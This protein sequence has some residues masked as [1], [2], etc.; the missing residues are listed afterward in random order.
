MIYKTNWSAEILR[1]VTAVVIGLSL[2]GLAGCV[3][4]P[5]T[6]PE[7]ADAIRSRVASRQIEDVASILTS[8][9]TG[10]VL[11]SSGT[12][13]AVFKPEFKQP[14]VTKGGMAGPLKW[15]TSAFGGQ[16]NASGATTGQALIRQSDGSWAGGTAGGTSS[17]TYTVTDALILGAATTS[18]VRL[19]L[20]SGTL[21]VREGD[22]SA[23]APLNCGLLAA[24]GSA[25]ISGTLSLAGGLSLT[26]ASGIQLRISESIYGSRSNVFLATIASSALTSG[27][28]YTFTGALPDGAIILG[29]SARITTT[30]SGPTS[31]QIG[32]GSD[33]DR[34][35]IFSTLTSGQTIEPSA[36][37]ASPLEWRS[38]AGDVVLTAVG[39]N[40]TAGVVRICVHYITLT[41]PTS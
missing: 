29:V 22:D 15:A 11:F 13:V 10:T 9:P 3:D 38:A 27:A 12:G 1:W 40:F 14:R 26:G 34:Y 35:G 7:R 5:S 37:T 23:Y 19:D 30:I 24:S 36:G 41:A 8:A 17:A 25:T 2:S 16:V 28:T 6:L 32:D 31:V 20:E 21:A 18:G 39:G 33:A 4:K